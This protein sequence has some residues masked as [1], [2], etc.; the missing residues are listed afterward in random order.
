[1][2]IHIMEV[3]T[4]CK[5]LCIAPPPKSICHGGWIKQPGSQ[6]DSD[7]DFASCCHWHYTITKSEIPGSK[8]QGWPQKGILLIW[9]L[10]C[11]AVI[12]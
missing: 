1:M 7:I 9:A 6:N 11:V 12:A 4:M 8:N 3:G 2:Q 5:G 10:E